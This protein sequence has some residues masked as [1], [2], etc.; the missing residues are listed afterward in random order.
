MLIN[1]NHYMVL[2]KIAHNR[3][4]LGSFYLLNADYHS[5]FH[6]LTWAERI[7]REGK[8]YGKWANSQLYHTLIREL[9]FVKGKLGNGGQLWVGL[10]NSGETHSLSH[11]ES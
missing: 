10:G 3:C 1:I 5:A 7:Y 4:L 2:D 11:R 8:E 9:D 6:M